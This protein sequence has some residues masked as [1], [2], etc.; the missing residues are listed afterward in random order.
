MAI[1]SVPAQAIIEHGFDGEASDDNGTVKVTFVYDDA[2]QELLDLPVDHP[3]GGQGRQYTSRA[4]MSEAVRLLFD[5]DRSARPQ[6]VCARPP[7]PPQDQLRLASMLGEPLTEELGN[8]S[9]E[10]A[11]SRVGL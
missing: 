4:I 1:E 3:E 9:P 11:H 6:L 5:L 7:I 8:I 10:R 2:T